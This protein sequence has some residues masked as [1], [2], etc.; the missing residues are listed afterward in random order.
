MDHTAAAADGSA[1]HAAATER[2]GRHDGTGGHRAYGAHGESTASS[3][4]DAPALAS[5]AAAQK[6]ILTVICDNEDQMYTFA[7]N[8]RIAAQDNATAA[9]AAAAQ[10]NDAKLNGEA[11]NGAKS[12]AEMKRLA[13]AAAAADASSGSGEH[14]EAVAPAKRTGLHGSRDGASG[15]HVPKARDAKRQQR[16]KQAAQYRQQSQAASKRH[17]HASTGMETAA[18]LEQEVGHIG[19]AVQ[20]VHL[21]LCHVILLLSALHSLHLCS[22]LNASVWPRSSHSA[23]CSTSQEPGSSLALRRY[24]YMQLPFLSCSG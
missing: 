2:S 17:P 18:N 4:A 3:G 9:S 23:Q 5:N 14:A 8:P 16:G 6:R 21:L 24:A 7:Y 13:A 12:W 15:V 11:H 19:R 20:S 1:P 22:R 10:A